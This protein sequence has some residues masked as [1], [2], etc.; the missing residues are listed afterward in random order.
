MTGIPG[1]RATAGPEQ[2]GA[3]YA[4]QDNKATL[5]VQFWSRARTS[6]RGGGSRRCRRTF[7][8]SPPQF[9]TGFTHLMFR[10]VDDGLS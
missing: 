10:E 6:T 5:R 8:M 3:R 9:R 4:R 1:R 2:I 7:T